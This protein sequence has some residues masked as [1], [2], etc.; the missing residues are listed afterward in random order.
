MIIVISLYNFYCDFVVCSI[1]FIIEG[2]I[3]RAFLVIFG[4]VSER[5]SFGFFIFKYIEGIIGIDRV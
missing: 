4:L 5:L 2:R 3:L 1:V